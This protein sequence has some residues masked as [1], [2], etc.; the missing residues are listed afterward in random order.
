MISKKIII[1]IVMVLA[2][3]TTSA[4][5][6]TPTS[7]KVFGTDQSISYTMTNGQVT[8]AIPHSQSNSLI[9]FASGTG[10]STL[11]LTLPRE[12]IDAKM[13]GKDS[14]FVITDDGLPTQFQE[15]NTDT[16]R[17]VTISFNYKTNPEI[18]MITGTHVVPEFGIMA[19]VTL[20]IS[21]IVIVLVTAR[22]KL[23]FM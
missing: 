8:D 4:F 14:A 1:F 3:G 20:V 23:R 18:F 16:T 22:T 12:L 2:L 17:T 5:A 13:G 10:S 19:S 21:T 9:I 6:Q 7:V 15:T 11:T